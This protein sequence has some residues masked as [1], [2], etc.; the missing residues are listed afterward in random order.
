MQKEPF[1]SGNDRHRKIIVS[2]VD[3]NVMLRRWDKAQFGGEVGWRA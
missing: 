1:K 2:E 3:E